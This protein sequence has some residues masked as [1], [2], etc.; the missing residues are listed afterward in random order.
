V[1]GVKLAGDMLGLEKE[2]E[3]LLTFETGETYNAEKVNNISQAIVDKFST[4]GYAFC[5]ATPNPV[6]NAEKD[7][8][9]IVYTIDPGRRAYVRHVNITGNTRTRDDVIRREVRQYESAWFDSDKVK[10]S[11]DRIDTFYVTDDEE[12]LLRTQTSPM[13]IR[14]MEAI[15]QPP[16]RILAPGR[17][18]RRGRAGGV[19]RL[20]YGAASLRTGG[21]R[22]LRRG[23]RGAFRR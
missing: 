12:V 14:A 19:R 1:S 21:A 18:Y 9:E 16:I 4:L 13:Q 15:G 5:T 3:P 10:L 17:G 11:R 23:R 2:I 8:V 20:G 6:A 22:T 7:T